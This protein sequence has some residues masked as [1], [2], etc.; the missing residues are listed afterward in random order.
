MH[1]DIEKMAT[2]IMAERKFSAFST[3]L[4]QLI[5]EEYERRRMDMRKPET[6]FRSDFGDPMGPLE[7]NRAN[8]PSKTPKN[9]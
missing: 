7:C 9:A 4:E 5:R 2:A 1:P 3:F 8:T 6:P